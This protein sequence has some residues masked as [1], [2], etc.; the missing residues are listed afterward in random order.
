MFFLFAF[1]SIAIIPMRS[2]SIP[3]SIPMM[4][5]EFRR[6]SRGSTQSS[7]VI[8]S[9]SSSEDRYVQFLENV[10]TQGLLA[11]LETDAVVLARDNDVDVVK[12]AAENAERQYQDLSGKT[13]TTRVQGGLSA[14]LCVLKLSRWGACLRRCY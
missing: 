8:V 9:L 1:E 11:L 3:A 4:I 12:K 6:R 7:L 2:S 5:H 13:V 14:D 10:I